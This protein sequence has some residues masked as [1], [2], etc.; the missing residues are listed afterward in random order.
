M[1]R[2]HAKHCKGLLGSCLWS[3]Y[4]FSHVCIF[5]SNLGHLRHGLAYVIYIKGIVAKLRNSGKIY[6]PWEYI[7]YVKTI[8]IDYIRRL[9]KDMPWEGG[10]NETSQY[11]AKMIRLNIIKQCNAGLWALRI[12]SKVTKD[13]PIIQFSCMHCMQLLE[14]VHAV[15]YLF[16]VHTCHL[17]IKNHIKNVDTQI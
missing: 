11:G 5:T 4:G 6:F 12:L 8:S 13:R 15:I 10:G 1:S 2:E 9:H 14:H 3:L 16:S 17:Q 7:K